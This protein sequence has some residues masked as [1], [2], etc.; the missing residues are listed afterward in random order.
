VFE[1]EEAAEAAMERARQGT[2]P[3][4]PATMVSSEIYEVLAQA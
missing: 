1:T 2:P 4:A 3:E